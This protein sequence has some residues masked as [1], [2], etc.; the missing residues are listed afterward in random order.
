MVVGSFDVSLQHRSYAGADVGALV[1][2]RVLCEQ[3][4]KAAL[5]VHTV[6]SA[7]GATEHVGAVE[8]VH[9]E[10]IRVLA[11]ERYAV[12]V[13]PDGRI[14]DARTYSA[15]VNSRRKARTVCGHRERRNVGAQC[16]EAVCADCV[17]LAAGQRG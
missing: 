8:L 2:H 11:Y 9:M 3:T 15:H 10:V 12:D 1:S 7:L 16:A 13:N 14:V 17:K 4:D 6:E 5:G